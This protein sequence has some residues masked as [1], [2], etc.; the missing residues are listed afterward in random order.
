MFFLSFFINIDSFKPKFHKQ[1]NMIKG[2][3]MYIYAPSSTL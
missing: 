1:F 3:N 2:A